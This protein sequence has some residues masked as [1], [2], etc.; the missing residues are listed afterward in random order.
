MA[1]FEV[2]STIADT[3]SGSPVSQHG[4]KESAKTPE[5]GP[6]NE[7]KTQMEQAYRELQR[8]M[9]I[10]KLGEDIKH[11]ILVLSGKGGVGKSTVA[12]G[13]ALSLAKKG[14]KVGLMDIDITGP[15]VPKMLGLDD[16]DLTVENEQIFPA[17]GPYGVKVI[18]MA[19]LIED[20]DKPVIW[21]G[22]IKLGA[23][24]Q[25]IGD[26]AWGKLDAL[27]VDFPPG[28]SDEPLTVSQHLPGI[29][30]VVIVTTPQEVALLDSRKS[31]N[32][33]KTISVPV[34][35]VVENMS[36][37]SIKGKGEPNTMISLMGPEGVALESKCD[38]E[39]N[40]SM[41]L[42]LFKKGGGISASNELNVPFLGS[43]PFDP[44]IVR[45]GD[46]GVHRIVAEPE[47][48]TAKAFDII[49]TGIL[50]SLNEDSGSSLKIT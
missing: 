3:M 1:I 37:Y 47:G 46:D 14:M 22:P 26:V 39:G 25:F 44:G 21:R 43:L 4:G 33:A 6:S 12:T 23:I 32:F 31:I 49:V 9:R 17:I 8:K 29:D 40:W 27:I 28:T 18:S 11:K 2:Q 34:L 5:S 20:P 24:Q 35:G 10:A 30:G 48:D 7:Q 42:D 36:G 41:V 50:N 45:G 19:F 13:L 15:N 38:K 16:T